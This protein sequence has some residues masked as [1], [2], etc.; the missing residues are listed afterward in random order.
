MVRSVS[1][2]KRSYERAWYL[3]VYMH[4]R[5][6]CNGAYTHGVHVRT[7]GRG[8]AAG[9]GAARAAAATSGGAPPQWPAAHRCPREADRGWSRS[10]S[11]RRASWRGTPNWRARARCSARATGRGGTCG[12]ARTAP[13]GVNG[14]ARGHRVHGDVGGRC[15]WRR[16]AHSAIA[17]GS[18][19]SSSLAVPMSVYVSAEAGSRATVC[20]NQRSASLA[21]PPASYSTSPRLR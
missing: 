2:P 11:S 20:P 21:R 19:P 1:G 16:G 13:C 15:V 17:A 10:R 7:R 3:C 4:G 14:G 12:V 18:S 5:A 8:T 9:R 6:G